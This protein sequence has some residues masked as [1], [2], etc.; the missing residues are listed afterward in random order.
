MIGGDRQQS[1]NISRYRVDIG[2]TERH[3]FSHVSRES[4]PLLRR[5]NIISVD[6]RKAARESC[7]GWNSSR[8]K[9]KIIGKPERFMV[10]GEEALGM[11]DEI[12]CWKAKCLFS[13]DVITDKKSGTRWMRS[14]ACVCV[15]M[16][17]K[18]YL[19]VYVCIYI[20]LWKLYFRD[21]I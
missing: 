16:N 14:R 10:I 9:K 4:S 13:S 3:D 11:R 19:C 21:S 5:E 6:E 20:Y 2:W 17:S 12:E 7:R 8:R 18:I 15:Q 1:L